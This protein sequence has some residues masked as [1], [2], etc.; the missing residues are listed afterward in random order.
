MTTAFT[1][2][3]PLHFRRPRT[4][5]SSIHPVHRPITPVCFSLPR[6][7]PETP[8]KERSVIALRGLAD[9]SAAAVLHELVLRYIVK[10]PL[11]A[12]TICDSQ[13][14]LGG[15]IGVWTAA[16]FADR[17]RDSTNALI[18]E[19]KS[20]PDKW[21]STVLYTPS[22]GEDDVASAVMWL[23]A[24]NE[25]DGGGLRDMAGR[26]GP[27]VRERMAFA[28]ADLDGASNVVGGVLGDLAR[29]ESGDVREAAQQAMGRIN[30]VSHRDTQPQRDEEE[31]MKLVLER[32][33]S[34]EIMQQEQVSTAVMDLIARRV[35]AL[36]AL[37]LSTP[38]FNKIRNSLNG[39]VI[40]QTSPVNQL[41]DESPVRLDLPLLEGLR[42]VEVHGLTTLAIFPALYELCSVG[43]G[44]DLPLRFVGLG[45]LLTFSG[46]VAY[47]QSANLWRKFSKT[48]DNQVQNRV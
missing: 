22:I 27:A 41:E 32:L 2:S 25:V 3:V 37:A 36:S 1:T 16:A 35:E 15:L 29:D 26:G 44:T 7:A 38:D 24:L 17:V 12:I 40:E 34:D 19:V 4:S 31:D 30:Q 28:L 18:R 5:S 33:F 14:L 10:A 45:W 39:A 42:R 23:Q 11:P 8:L 46:L 43:G 48:M 21:D 9:L 20:L 13:L 6:I 47:P